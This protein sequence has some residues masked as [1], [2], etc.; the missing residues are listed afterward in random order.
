MLDLHVDVRFMGA[1][2]SGIPPA[3]FCTLEKSGKIS[4]HLCIRKAREEQT[5]TTAIGTLG[6][7]RSCPLSQQFSVYEIQGRQP[8]SDPRRPASGFRLPASDAGFTYR[9]RTL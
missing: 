7:P 4:T 3:G 8:T 2:T 1:H 9:F 6:P 5:P